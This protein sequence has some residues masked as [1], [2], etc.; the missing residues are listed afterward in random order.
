MRTCVRV[1]VCVRVRVRVRAR[2]CVLV[3]VFY[4]N[5]RAGINFRFQNCLLWVECFYFNLNQSGNSIIELPC[6]LNLISKGKQLI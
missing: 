2:A 6:A 3:C 5:Y 1:C 4:N